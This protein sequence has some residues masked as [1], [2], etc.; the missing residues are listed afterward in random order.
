MATGTVLSLYRWP[1]KSM[2]GEAVD[3]LAVDERGAAGDRAHVVVE[4]R[5]GQEERT[6]T[7]RQAPRLLAWR[8]GYGLSAAAELP[9]DDVPAAMVE[10]PDGRRLRWDAP[11]LEAAL[12]TDLRRDVRLERDLGLRQDLPASLLVT[13]ES[14]RRAVGRALGRDLD[15][16]RTRTNIHVALDAEPYAEEG[17]EGERI[18][19]GPGALDLLHPCERCVI[20]TRDPETQERWPE[21]L[22]WLTR[23]HAGR[24]GINARAVG[25]ATLRIGDRVELVHRSA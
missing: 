22:R 2:G 16:R 17:W 21:L 19:I 8:A 14:T 18:R 15:L 25:P 3:V 5:G 11:E 9:V 1:V 12:S 7:A 4:R 10:A 6:L 23:E 20:P 13:V 24:F